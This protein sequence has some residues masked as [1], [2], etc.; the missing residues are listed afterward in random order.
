[1]LNQCLENIGEGLLHACISCY[2]FNAFSTVFHNA[3]LTQFTLSYLFSTDRQLF[4]HDDCLH[5]NLYIDTQ[6]L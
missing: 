4:S 3:R 6:I 2:I 5:Y 1:M